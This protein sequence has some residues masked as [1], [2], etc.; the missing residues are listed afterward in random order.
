MPLH[1]LVE[2]GH[3][4]GPRCS[5]ERAISTKVLGFVDWECKMLLTINLV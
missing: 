2:H 4:S 5:G 3:S 1:S